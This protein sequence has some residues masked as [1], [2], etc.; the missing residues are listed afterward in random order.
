MQNNNRSKPI[1]IL[2]VED[3][4]DDI[5]IIKQSMRRCNISVS[6]DIVRDGEKALH[7][8]RNTGEFVHAQRP[9]LILLDINLPKYNGLKVLRSIK[10]EPSLQAIPVVILT[11]SDTEEDVRTA[12]ML[13][14]SCYIPKPVGV[15]QFQEMVRSLDNFWFT[16]V[17]FPPKTLV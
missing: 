11:S 12:Y 8:V 16:I 3:D 15:K 13:Q 9:D 6:M 7:Y 14:A 1:H 4:A 2:L 5:F 17:Q 10:K